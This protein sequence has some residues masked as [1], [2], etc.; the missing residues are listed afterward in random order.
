MA[1]EI[2]I[3][4]EPL[5]SRLGF[6]EVVLGLIARLDAEHTAT[7]PEDGATHFR[8]DADELAPG[9]GVFLV[10]YLAGAPVGCGAVR[11]IAPEEAELK[12]MFVT[13]AARGCG[14]G[15]ALLSAL[16]ACARELG[17]ERVVLETGVRQT[18][19]LGLYRR[20]GYEPVE[21]WGEYLDSPLSVCMGR[22]LVVP[23]ASLCG[24]RK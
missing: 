18:E 9:R 24:P 1:D 21:P 4:R 16:E 14:V 13:K 22:R 11:L 15:A 17:A 2:D 5:D 3:R 10:A 6:S 12:R 20:A 23:G 8:L 19:A 7:Y